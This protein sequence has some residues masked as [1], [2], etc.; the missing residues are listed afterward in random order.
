MMCGAG[1]ICEQMDCQFIDSVIIS[2]TRNLL[3]EPRAEWATTPLHPIPQILTLLRSPTSP[4]PSLKPP[5]PPTVANYVSPYQ[6][7]LLLPCLSLKS[8]L[9]IILQLWIW[10]SA[11]SPNFPLPLKGGTGWIFSQT[12]STSTLLLTHL[13]GKRE[14]LQWRSL[15]TWLNQARIPSL[16]QP[17]DDS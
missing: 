7:C 11:S 3:F 5:D 8:K 15:P 14:N 2:I 12:P 17:W 1:W 9:G 10:T 4:L 13:P 16:T 6:V